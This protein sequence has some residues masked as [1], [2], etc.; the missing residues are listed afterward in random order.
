MKAGKR[1]RGWEERVG[2]KEER[3]IRKV[4]KCASKDTRRVNEREYEETR[5]CI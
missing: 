4:K 2:E 5:E 1:R 3:I